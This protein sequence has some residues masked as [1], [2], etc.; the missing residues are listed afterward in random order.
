M[1]IGVLLDEPSIL[2][3]FDY[4]FYEVKP[5]SGR[6]LKPLRKAW[7]VVNCFADNTTSQT[8]PDLVATCKGERAV[9]GTTKRFL[10]DWICP[11]R[12]E[13]RE[14][15]KRIIENVARDDIAGIRL[16]SVCF[17]REGYCDCPVCTDELRKSGSDFAEW[18]AHQIESFIREVR[19]SIPCSLGL[20]LEP[21]PCYGKERFGLDMEGISR[22]V[23]F[24]S[25]P[26]YMDYSIVYWLDIIANCFR[27]KSSKPY[28]IELYAG[29]P[30]TPTK[31]L[32]SALA[33]ASAYADC[34][35]LSTYETKLAMGLQREL[36]GDEG[37]WRFF[38]ER[39]CQ[40][41][42][43]VL[44]RWRNQNSALTMKEGANSNR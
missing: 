20:T 11:S 38:E 39:K 1:K 12:S 2:P 42:L 28:F 5:S 24:F 41:M 43:D 16:D 32:V 30:R 6:I 33:V 4:T 23:D 13:Y 37:V 15:C 17:P 18:R 7:N 40:Q 44:L 35:V 19:E 31:Y 36:A 25:T 21:D 14:Y 27:R 34:L 29:H 22:Y 9:R 3:G 10:W 8:K 26:L